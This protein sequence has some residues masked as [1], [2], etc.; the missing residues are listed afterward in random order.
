MIFS[1]TT[2][3]TGQPCVE[4]HDGK[5]LI[6]KMYPSADGQIIRIFF[7]ELHDKWQAMI[8][9]ENKIVE[10][11][12]SGEYP[13]SVHVRPAPAEVKC[14]VKDCEDEASFIIHKTAFC[15]RHRI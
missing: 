3:K 13:D 7:S 9:V 2:T 14:S 12:R 4:M 15:M 10:F 6:A 8:S 1:L 5:L 11:S